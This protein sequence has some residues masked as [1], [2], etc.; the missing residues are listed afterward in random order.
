MTHAAPELDKV[1]AEALTLRASRIDPAQWIGEKAGE[2]SPVELLARTGE[3]VEHWYWGRLVHDFAGMVPNGDRVPIDYCHDSGEVLGFLNEF[4]PS[5]GDL[6]TR[7]AL[8]HFAEKDRV[9]E[10]TTKGRAGVPYEASID[11]RGEGVVVEYIDEGQMTEVNGRQLEGPLA[12][13]RKWPL[14]GVAICPYGHDAGTEARFN[15]AETFTVTKA[16]ETEPDPMKKRASTQ[17]AGLLGLAIDEHNGAEAQA[18]YVA[19]IAKAAG[20]T[21]EQLT[22][23]ETH[24]DHLELEKPA[25]TFAQL[26][27]ALDIDAGDVFDAAEKDGYK[28]ER[29]KPEKQPPADPP[30]SGDAGKDGPAAQLT[31][32]QQEAGRYVEAFGDAGAAMWAQGLTFEQA[33]AKHR[34][35]EAAR[36]AGIEDENKKLK[37]Q[38]AALE[39]SGGG[40]VDSGQLD[41]GATPPTDRQ[42]RTLANRIRIVGANTAPS[43]N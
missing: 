39:Q 41:G 36:F 19:G 6:V 2:T 22:Q 30:G 4:D 16:P 12:V 34:E 7:G 13:I 5:S 3:P 35:T 10:V 43:N 15:Q 31:E 38:V 17:L 9:A 26:A 1:P 14:R 18:E 24:A 40:A 28:F 32:A 11:F 8:V 27:T 25:E 29:P 21:T 42:K 23:M 20:L 37:A 33:A